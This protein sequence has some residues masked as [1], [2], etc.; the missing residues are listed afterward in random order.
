MHTFWWRSYLAATIYSFHDPPSP[1]WFL[2]SLHRTQLLG[3]VSLLFAIFTPFHMR[4]QQQRLC[5]TKTM[6]QKI[7]SHLNGSVGQRQVEA[8]DTISF[9]LNMMGFCAHILQ[10]AWRYDRS[11]GPRSFDFYSFFNFINIIIFLSGNYFAPRT[12]F[13]PA[14]WRLPRHVWGGETSWF[15]T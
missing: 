15:V 2:L 1:S 8:S 14:A 6:W 4:L 9:L 11:D 10:S 7:F 3:I 13:R 12:I 5:Q